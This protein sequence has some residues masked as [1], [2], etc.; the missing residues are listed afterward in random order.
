MTTIPSR[1]ARVT[2]LSHSP[3][4]ARAK[5]IQLYRDWY[6]A[7][8]RTS[9]S[10]RIVERG[11]YNHVLAFQA[12]E[13]VSIYTLNVS[14]P[15]FRQRIRARFEEN[16]HVT[17]IRLIDQ[18]AL[19]DRQEY[20]ETMNFWKQPDHVMGILLQPK[21]RPP[22]TFLQKFYEGRCSERSLGIAALMRSIGRDEDQ[23]LPAA[24]GT[25]NYVP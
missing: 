2:R 25:V 23:V 19:R 8:R 5:V 6:R 15:Y 4:E 12:P 17:D 18:L 16:R 11:S 1:L 13:I 9:V 3:E 10:L 7:V 22:R 21:G 24:T 20:Q 14:V